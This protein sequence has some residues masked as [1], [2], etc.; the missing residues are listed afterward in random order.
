MTSFWACAAQGI[1]T[2]A[3][4]KEKT[5]STTAQVFKARS[6][7]RIR[8]R[9]SQDGFVYVADNSSALEMEKKER[10]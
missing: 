8:L 5:E 7:K 4:T 1:P 3:V 2:A 6:P 9:G 10:N